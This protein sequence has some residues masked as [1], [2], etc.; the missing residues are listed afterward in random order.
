MDSRLVES[1]VIQLAT[2][3]EGK[4]WICTIYFVVLGNDI[5]WLSYPNRK[6]SEQIAH[7][8][9]VAVTAVIKTDIPVVSISVEGEAEV[10][11]DR[12]TVKEVME[13]YVAKYGEGSA[14]F[15]RFVAGTNKHAMYKLRSRCM[16]V[17]DEVAGTGEDARREYYFA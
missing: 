17:F 12:A 2:Q 5:F 3:A 1:R 15:E 13:A 14:F 9:A 10:I 11:T 6:H 4:P 16:T 8:P 7:N